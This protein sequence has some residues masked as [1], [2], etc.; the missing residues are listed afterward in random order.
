MMEKI[1]TKLENL[2]MI[3]G[4]NIIEKWMFPMKNGCFLL[5][6]SFYKNMKMVLFH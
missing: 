1:V 4:K 5:I 6:F 3:G 2:K